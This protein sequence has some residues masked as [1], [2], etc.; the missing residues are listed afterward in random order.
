[1]KAFAERRIVFHGYKK[2]VSLCMHHTGTTLIKTCLY[3]A[4]SS[5]LA[6]ESAN[7]FDILEQRISSVEKGLVDFISTVIPKGHSTR[8]SVICMEYETLQSLLL[9]PLNGLIRPLLGPLFSV[10]SLSFSGAILLFRLP[11]LLRSSRSVPA[12]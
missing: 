12:S 5:Q 9:S 8:R 2:P 7:V 6:S 11:F 10:A 1:M 4:S 3:V